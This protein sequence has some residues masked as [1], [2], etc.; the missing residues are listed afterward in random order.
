M[1]PSTPR[2][3]LERSESLIT[4]SITYPCWTQQTQA[5]GLESHSDLT[6]SAFNAPA[7]ACLMKKITEARAKHMK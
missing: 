7:E 6:V 2:R 4:I 1:Q 3:C 5:W